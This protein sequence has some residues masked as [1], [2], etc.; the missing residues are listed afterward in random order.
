MDYE[1]Y[2]KYIENTNKLFVL[3]IFKIL[4]HKLKSIIMS[5]LIPGQLGVFVGRTGD[6]VVVP[7]GKKY[8]GRSVPTKSTKPRTEKQVAQ[9]DKMKLLYGLCANAQDFFKIS[10][11]ESA[12]KRDDNGYNMC[13]SYNLIHAIKG[14]S[15]NQYLDWGEVIIAD[16]SRAMPEKVIVEMKPDGFHFSWSEDY[17]LNNGSIYDRAMIFIYC[18][19]ETTRTA[20]NFSGAMRKELKDFHPLTS[21]H[22]GKKFEVYIAFKDVRSNEVSRSVYGGSFTFDL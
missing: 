15:P 16:G 10:F 6:V 4:F 2:Y 13:K 5:K 14:E 7:L 11:A 19:H 1:I 18:H 17:D 20:F 22:K 8:I 12:D 9:N 21:Y 3:A